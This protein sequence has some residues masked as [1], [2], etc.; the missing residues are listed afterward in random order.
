M[1]LLATSIMD[2]LARNWAILVIASTIITLIVVP[3]VIIMKYVRISLNIMRTTKPPLARGPLDFD[4]LVG[5]PVS[6]PAYDG[7]PLSGMLIRAGPDVARR[8]LI[9]FAHEFCSDM[10]SCARYCRPLQRAGYD[11]LTFDFRGHGL[12]GCA[13]DYTPR[14]WVTDRDLDDMRGAA[15]FA[16]RWLEEQA[17]PVEFG[18]F[19]ISRGACAAILVA[20]ENPRIRVLVSDG[21]FSTDTTIEYFMKRWAYIFAKVRFV[22]ENHPPVFW[23]FLRWSMFLFARWEFKCRFPSVRKAIRRMTPRPMLFIHGE[24]DSYLPVEQSRRLYALA[25]QPKQL[26]IAP[27]TRHNQAVIRH[28]DFYARLTTDFFAQHLA[29]VTLPVIAPAGA[30]V[31]AIGLPVVPAVESETIPAPLAHP[32]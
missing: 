7:L 22:Y 14:Q 25:G 5:E 13:P 9:V 19:G 29:P 21:G 16:E 6:F 20:L 32:G 31:A 26:W 28:P 8:G 15:A 24:N 11:I 3:A 23:R 27:G 18:A 4:R 12:S 2:A 17:Y 30:E 1:S 10:H